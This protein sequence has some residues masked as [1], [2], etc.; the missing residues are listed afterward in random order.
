MVWLN[1]TL[2]WFAVD[3]FATVPVDVLLL[4]SVGVLWIAVRLALTK[5]LHGTEHVLCNGFLVLDNFFNDHRLWEAL[6]NSF[7]L[8]G[9][10][11]SSEEPLLSVTERMGEDVSS[12]ISNFRVAPVVVSSPLLTWSEVAMSLL[13]HLGRFFSFLETASLGVENILSWDAV[14][15]WHTETVAVFLS[16]PFFVT[17]LV[18]HS[19]GFSHGRL[20]LAFLCV[21]ELVSKT[22]QVLSLDNIVHWLSCLR[23]FSICVFKWLVWLT[24][25]QTWVDHDLARLEIVNL[26]VLPDVGRSS[27]VTFDFTGIHI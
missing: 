2:V 18:R 26:P 23:L 7:W 17:T 4:L 12:S 21:I 13:V 20:I 5:V 1:F 14:V 16:G 22:V 3:A 19:E 27:S 8:D 24:F 9:L 6:F 11:S 10:G 25:L 15:G